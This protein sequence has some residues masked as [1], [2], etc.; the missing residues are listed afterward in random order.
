MSAKTSRPPGRRQRS[1][2]FI[3]G[4]GFA[5]ACGEHR[6]G[7]VD[8]N[9]TGDRSGEL[10]PGSAGPGRHVEQQVVGPQLEAVQD[11]FEFGARPA[12]RAAS[13]EGGRLLRERLFD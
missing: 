8:C 5:T 3:C 11:P 7:A 4:F 12:D 10:A 1:V 2:S 9:H 13:G 6:L